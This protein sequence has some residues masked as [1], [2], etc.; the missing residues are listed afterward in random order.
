[1]VL[2]GCAFPA[3]LYY[4]LA[5][6]C[7][8]LFFPLMKNIFFFLFENK[9]CFYSLDSPNSPCQRK[10]E[11]KFKIMKT[12]TITQIKTATEA[13]APHFFSR[14]TLKFF[15][16][17]MESFKVLSDKES[18]RI[19]IAAKSGGAW[20]NRHLTLREFVNGDSLRPVEKENLPASVLDR[21]P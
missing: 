7:K 10:P 3:S 9:T 18:G 19:F 16:Q 11:T 6:H 12:P 2:V 20:G 4:L 14:E 5:I 17:S 13:T 15:G 1:M 8:V 21:L